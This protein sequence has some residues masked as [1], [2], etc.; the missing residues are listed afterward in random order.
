MGHHFKYVSSETVDLTK[1]VVDGFVALPGSATERSLKPARIEYLQDVVLG[2]SA[3]VFQWAQAKVTETGEIYRVNGQHSSYMLSQL[4]GQ[5]PNGLKV[6]KDT[7]EV[8][9]LASLAYLF[10]MFDPRTSARSVHDVAG[11]YQG[12]HLSL[13]DVPKMTAKM[14]IDG[15]SWFLKIVRGDNIPSGDDR[16]ELFNNAKMHPFIRMAGG[17]LNKIKTPEFTNPVIGAMYGTWEREPVE[18]EAF[19]SDV[20][21]QGG[22]NDSNHPAAVLDTWL[23]AIRDKTIEKKPSDREIYRACI[24]A[25]NAYRHHRTLDKIG[26]YDPKKGA[27]D[28][29]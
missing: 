27:P 26:K 15:T 19:W 25:W 29:D 16:Y 10:R 18:A 9:N 7:Y 5:F 8:D 23:V 6:H 13:K 11:A 22:G 17:I 1:A 4:N 24:V 2:G 21:K 12:L 28:I 3:V 20:A 14:T